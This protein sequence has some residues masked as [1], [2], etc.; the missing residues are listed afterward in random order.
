MMVKT[1]T[2]TLKLPTKTVIWGALTW[3]AK[4]KKE[5]KGRDEKL[6]FVEE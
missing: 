2:L 4:I 5:F 6:G 3:T 1:D